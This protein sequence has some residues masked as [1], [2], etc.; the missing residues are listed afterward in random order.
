MG[1]FILQQIIQGVFGLKNAHYSFPNRIWGRVK[2]R[3][4]YSILTIQKCS[5]PG[6][7]FC[8]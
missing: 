1:F 8:V 6:L 5:V 3:I 2:W 7:L 4:K